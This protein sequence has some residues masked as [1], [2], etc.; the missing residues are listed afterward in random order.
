MDVPS[1]FSRVSSLLLTALSDVGV[2][3]RL[4]L[5]ISRRFFFCF[6]ARSCFFDAD[7]C[8]GSCGR[9]AKQLIFDPISAQQVEMCA[10]LMTT[11]TP[12]TKAKKKKHMKQ[13]TTSR[14]RMNKIRWKKEEKKKRNKRTPILSDDDDETFIAFCQTTKTTEQSYHIVTEPT[15]DCC[16]HKKRKKSVHIR[17]LSNTVQRKPQ[18]ERRK[19][20]THINKSLTRLCAPSLGSIR[21][22]ITHQKEIHMKRMLKVRN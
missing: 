3:L 21:H 16:V 20:N 1:F 15:T 11:M 2:T 14:T 12:K 8:Y 22:R 10:D 17:V 4:L 19:K 5:I 9:V 7:I 13:K 6:C 18:H